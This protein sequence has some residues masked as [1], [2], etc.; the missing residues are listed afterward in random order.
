MSWANEI[1]KEAWYCYRPF[2]IQDPDRAAVYQKANSILADIGIQHYGVRVHTNKGNYW[3]IHNAKSPKT[4]EYGIYVTDAEMSKNWSYEK[5]EVARKDV[6]ISECQIVMGWTGGHKKEDWYKSGT[7][8]FAARTLKE[9]LS[10]P[11]YN[12]QSGFN[13]IMTKLIGRMGE[14]SE[15]SAYDKRLD[16]ILKDK[17]LDDN[18]KF[19]MAFDLLLSTY[20]NGI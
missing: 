14:P 13:A 17:S 11:N 2:N 18:V 7:C 5:I 1:V 19:D 16:E 3:L 9:Y 8:L 6:T 4:S 10:D 20:D 15:P 12:Y